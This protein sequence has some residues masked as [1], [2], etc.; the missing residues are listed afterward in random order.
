MRIRALVLARPTCKHAAPP[1]REHVRAE[2]LDDVVVKVLR[3]NVVVPPEVSLGNPPCVFYP[4]PATSQCPF[5]DIK[6]MWPRSA[7]NFSSAVFC[8]A[9]SW[10]LLSASDKSASTIPGRQR[11]RSHAIS[12][13][14]WVCLCIRAG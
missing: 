14:P 10:H 11:P 7:T 9:K 3:D 6:R 12:S 2:R 8:V 13:C 4:S 1:K 5:G